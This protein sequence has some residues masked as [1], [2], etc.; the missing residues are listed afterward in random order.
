MWGLS[1]AGVLAATG[2][3]NKDDPKH[4]AE[5]QSQR[6]HDHVGD[7][8]VVVEAFLDDVLAALRWVVEAVEGGSDG[9]VFFFVPLNGLHVGHHHGTTEWR[10]RTLQKS[11]LLVKAWTHKNKHLMYSKFQAD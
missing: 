8:G 4:E 6:P 10:V 2:E 1:F 7:A 3:G 9:S 5:R 11:Q